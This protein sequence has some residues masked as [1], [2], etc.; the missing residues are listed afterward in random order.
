M[1]VISWRRKR[2]KKEGGKKK[3]KKT[4]KKNCKNIAQDNLHTK[5]NWQDKNVMDMLIG[6]CGFRAKKDKNKTN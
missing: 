1:T 3:K 4:E 5:F 6:G 2:R